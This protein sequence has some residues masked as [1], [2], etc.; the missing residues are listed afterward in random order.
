MNFKYITSDKEILGGKPIIAGTRISVDY[1]LQLIASGGS[2]N[3][4]VKK[5]PQLNQEAVT[6]A[7]LYAGKV[8]SN[9]IIINLRNV[10]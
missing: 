8:V 6:E 5:Y 1:I 3:E 7:V 4:I 10:A 9:E 2:I